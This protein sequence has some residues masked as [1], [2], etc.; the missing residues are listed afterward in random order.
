MAVLFFFIGRCHEN[1]C[2]RSATARFHALLKGDAGLLAAAAYLQLLGVTGATAYNI[3]N[4]Y[5][6]QSCCALLSK[7]AQASVEASTQSQKPT[8][9]KNSQSASQ[10]AKACTA[11]QRW[12]LKCICAAPSAGGHITGADGRR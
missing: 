2:V 8:K 11:S 12:S 4:G 9:R 1:V 5:V 6:F 7:V 3:F 10:Q